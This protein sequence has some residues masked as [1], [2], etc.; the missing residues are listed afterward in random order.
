MA[1]VAKYKQ[2]D[3][4]GLAIHYERREGSEL[5]NKDIDKSKS[6]ENYNLS[7]ELQPLKT[8]QFV[9]QRL[10]EVHHINRKDIIVM[11]DWIVTLPKNVP[12][13]DESKFFACTYDYLK[14]QYGEKNVIGAWVHK[15]ETTPH[16]HFSFVPVIEE[17]GKEKLN[18]KKIISKP[19]LKQFHPALANYLEMH[20][21]YMPEILNDATINGNRTVREL[22]MKEDLSFK[23]VVKSVD[24]HLKVSEELLAQAES[25]DYE[26]SN[27]LEKGK[28]LKKC[29]ILIDELKHSH[30]VLQSDNNV[31]NNLVIVQKQEIN[32]YRKMPLAKKLEEKE[33]IVNN[34]YNSIHQLENE[35]DDYKNDNKLLR[36]EMFRNDNKIE[37]LEQEVY[38]HKT[39]VSMLGL[40]KIYNQ[41]K[42]LFINNDYSL[43]FRSLIEICSKSMNQLQKI[44]EYLMDRLCFLERKHIPNEKVEIKRFNKSNYKDRTR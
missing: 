33:K 31:L 8:E 38:V 36:D 42:Q 28:T 17:D 13:Q 34:L 22:K 4:V 3:T 11:V 23:A 39:F 15:D 14:N 6:H 40:D 19:K 18:C 27:F 25:I 35:I 37:K 7:S 32:R 29:N 21:G 43:D 16:L 9:K 44:K 24:E 5:S 2:S 10:S 12:S 20:L 1:H 26:P 41:F 30:K